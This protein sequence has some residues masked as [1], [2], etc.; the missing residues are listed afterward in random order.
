MSPQNKEETSLKGYGKI[1]NLDDKSGKNGGQKKQTPRKLNSENH[2]FQTERET[3]FNFSYCASRHEFQWINSSLSSFYQQ[4]WLD[5]VLRLI[6]GGKEATVYLCKAGDFVESDFIAAKV[7]R[8]RRFRNLKKDHIYREG[9]A[10]LDE[11]GHVIHNSGDLH[12]MAKRTH[13]GKELLHTS[14]VEHE[15]KTLQALYKAGVD[16][17][18]PYACGNNAILME[19]FGSEYSP[20]PTLN[21]INLPQKEARQV[22]ERVLHNIDLMLANQRIHA[23]LSAYNILYWEGQIRIIDFPQA[24]DPR[25]NHQSFSIFRRDVTRVCDY[26]TLQGVKCAPRAIA[27]QLWQAHQLPFIHPD[28]ILELEETEPEE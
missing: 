10:N 5:D 24:I 27:E 14:W 9:R 1:R 28:A 16:L 22:F 18:Q 8:P 20:A 17:P 12:A 25:Q 11:N 15:F 23:D 2:E 26:F 7:Y 19:Y 4:Q 21:S 3:E 6:K 13:Y